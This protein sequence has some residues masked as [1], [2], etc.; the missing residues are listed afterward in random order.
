MTEPDSN[1]PTSTSTNP[2]KASRKRDA[3]IYGTIAELVQFGRSLM[4]VAQENLEGRL[5]INVYVKEDGGP[6][7]YVFRTTPRSMRTIAAALERAASATSD[8]DPATDEAPRSLPAPRRQEPLRP[9]GAPPASFTAT[10]ASSA[11]A[12]LAAGGC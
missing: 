12:A 6:I 5:V 1:E 2:P 11:S 3:I 8:P 10:M 9:R 7:R 4:M